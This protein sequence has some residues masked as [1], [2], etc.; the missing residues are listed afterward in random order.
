[1]TTHCSL[2]ISLYCLL[3]FFIVT[4]FGGPAWAEESSNP[5]NNWQD[6]PF[7][8]T[9]TRDPSGAVPSGYAEWAAA[10][11]VE[12]FEYR[13][14]ARQESVNKG[15]DANEFA[16]IVNSSLL[17]SIQTSI[18]QYLLDLTAAGFTGTVY[19]MSGGTP[20]S[21]RA[22]LQTL[23]AASV[24]GAVLIGDLPVAWYEADCW[25]PVEHEEFPCDLFYMDM[26]GTWEDLD[27]DGKYDYHTGDLTPEIWVGRLTASP[28]SYGGSSEAALINN[29]FDKN[30]RYRTGQMIYKNRGLAFI[31]DDWCTSGWQ[32][33]LGRAYDSVVSITDEYTTTAPNYKN[34]FVASYESVLL[35]AHS[36]PNT[37][38]FKTPADTWT[39]IDY[40]EIVD[41]DPMAGFYNL[42]N[43][44]GARYT[45]SN[46]L[47]GWYIFR[48]DYGLAA[49][50][51]AKTGS[52]LEFQYFY[53]SWDQGKTF[54]QA[55]ANWFTTVGNDGYAG[56]EI[57]WYYGMTLCGDPTL[58]KSPY[59][60]P[61][62]MTESID[63][64]MLNVEFSY[65]FEAQGGIAPYS[66]SI[67]SGSLPSGIT[68]DESAGSIS[69][70]PT[71]VGDYN[72]TLRVDDAN[73][74]SFAALHTY[75]MSVNYVCG[76]A[77]GDLKINIADAVYII[78]YIFSSGGPS[79]PVEAMDGNCDGSR[80]IGDAIYMV[81]H[82]FKSGPA[83]CCP[84]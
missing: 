45:S 29:Y 35:C 61:E 16:I 81:N 9:V 77:N 23:Y 48:D 70:M 1:M 72:F 39:T 3:I 30:H 5:A 75:E 44:S 74:P 67:V 49:V 52:M 2:R 17:A 27:I 65:S 43:C 12:P 80:N 4:G 84:Q 40:D 55:F 22:F 82:I 50:G 63:D 73:S 53:P 11:P 31:D 47:G 59:T 34:Q 25:D 71:V 15:T 28:L 41:Y 78:N 68:L 21:L 26:D 38:W 7:G 83:P 58:T 20:D 60:L 19:T 24:V 51:S 69:G 54:G 79:Y 37:H 10:H 76:D 62:I 6:N 42:F 36:S 14:V 57:C 32:N 33:D 13:Q 66:W 64:A 18:D 8:Y 56:W 46:Y